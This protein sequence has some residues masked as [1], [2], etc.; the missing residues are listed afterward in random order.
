M[1]RFT[2][3]KL[4]AVLCVLFMVTSCA[5]IPQKDAF[6]VGDD[7]KPRDKQLIY[8]LPAVNAGVDESLDTELDKEGIVEKV[9][10]D[11]GYRFQDE[12]QIDPDPRVTPDMLDALDFAWV[13]QLPLK[14]DSWV[15]I[16][17]VDY[18]TRYGYGFGFRADA[19]VTGE[20]VDV[21]TGRLVWEGVGYGTMR[22]GFLMAAL[23]DDGALEMAMKD[24]MY[25]L[26]PRVTKSGVTRSRGELIS[27]CSGSACDGGPTEAKAHICLMRDEGTSSLDGKGSGKG[28]MK[29]KVRIAVYILYDGSRSL[30]HL[31]AGQYRCWDRAPGRTFLHLGKAGKPAYFR[32]APGMTYYW[33]ADYKWG[34]GWV[35]DQFPTDKGRVTLAG[36]AEAAG[37]GD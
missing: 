24:L 34:D 9:I 33:H 15:L 22:M 10:E 16:P 3:A 19:Y 30:G 11:R 5:S 14:K 37:E 8:L 29:G 7:F 21:S 20:L 13:K 23:V 18:L 17:V 26:P 6:Y 25:S 2:L 32:A 31:P 1:G 36:Y 12:T 27:D 28:G 4:V 35:Y